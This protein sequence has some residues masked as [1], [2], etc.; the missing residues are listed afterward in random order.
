MALTRRTRAAA[1]TSVAGRGAG[2]VKKGR[3]RPDAHQPF[4]A[5]PSLL[6]AL[7]GGL[8]ASS[9]CLIQL[10]LNAFGFAC[11]GFAVLDPHRPLSVAATA[12]AL[13][14]LHRRHRSARVTGCALLAAAALTALP[15]LLAAASR[16]GGVGSALRAALP[17][18]VA[19]VTATDA[20]TT[21]LKVGMKCA[22]CGERA[23]AAAAGVPGIVSAATDW[24]AGTMRV[25]SS[26]GGSSEAVRAVE[27]ALAEAGF[28]VLKK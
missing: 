5:L 2:A 25:V 28:E 9:C 8:A 19:R 11:A 7:A 14:L 22:A 15:D 18:A 1:P 27:A 10:A 12:A 13:A 21:L 20:T 17:Q 26:G 4:S 23:R 3:G 6:A 16:A 24:E